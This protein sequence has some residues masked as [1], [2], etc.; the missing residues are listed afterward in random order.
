MGTLQKGQRFKGREM[1]LIPLMSNLQFC[2]IWGA[3]LLLRAGQTTGK[4]TG[5]SVLKPW[6]TGFYWKL[7]GLGRWPWA[8][9]GSTALTNSL[10][11]ALWDPEQKTQLT[12]PQT[13]DPEIL[14]D[15][16]AVSPEV[17]NYDNMFYCARKR[18]HCSF[19]IINLF[20]HGLH[21]LRLGSGLLQPKH[22]LSEL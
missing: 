8:S 19:G 6:G 2:D 20:H 4:K 21:V 1:F 22:Q 15:H 12:H 13:L 5:T 18:I 14:K 7:G 3:F 11:A 9:D 17:L 10:I 16:K